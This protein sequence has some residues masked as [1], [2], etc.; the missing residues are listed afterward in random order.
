VLATIF[1]GLLFVG[2]LVNWIYDPSRERL[3]LVDSTEYAGAKSQA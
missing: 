1:A 2:M 3:A